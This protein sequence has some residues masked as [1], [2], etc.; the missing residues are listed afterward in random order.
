MIVGSGLFGSTFASQALR[1]S[2]KVL[3]VERRSH[4][5]GNTF[6]KQVEKIHVH[7]YGPHFFHTNNKKIWDFINSFGEFN[8]FKAKAKAKYKNELYSLP[9]NL[10][11]FQQLWGT[12]TPEEARL[13]LEEDIVPISRPQNLEEWAISQVGVEIYDKFIKEFT[14]KQWGRSPKELPTSIIKRIPIRFTFNDHYHDSIYSGVPIKGYNPIIE[15]MIDGSKVW[16]NTDFRSIKNWRKIA[17]RLIFSGSIDELFDHKYGQLQY[18]S[19]RFSPEITPYNVQGIAQINYTEGKVPYSRKI[20]YIHLYNEVFKKGI[21]VKE[22][23]CDYVYGINDPLYPISDAENI[24]RYN[25][26][27][28][29]IDEDILVGGRLGSFRYIDMDQTIAMALNTYQSLD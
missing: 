3:I 21:V 14:K 16:L 13:R 17:D 5:G 19:M 20:E 2:K 4:I 23:H 7:Q 11:T 27:K 22:Y 15:N 12:I 18:R 1:D 6:C 10:E 28:R 26:Y 29:L 8:T 24:K 9:F 25:K